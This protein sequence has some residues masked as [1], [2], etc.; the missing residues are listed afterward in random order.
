[1]SGGL[2][3]ADGDVAI[4]WRRG[5]SLFF[6]ALETAITIKNISLQ[7]F[8]KTTMFLHCKYHE[9]VAQLALHHYR[10]N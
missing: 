2:T 3:L 4:K 6:A 5:F 7:Y 10:D 9:H 8:M 1:M